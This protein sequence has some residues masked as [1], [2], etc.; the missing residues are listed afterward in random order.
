MRK[1]LLAVPFVFA[2]IQA[3][4]ACS[5]AQD[6]Q[7]KATEMMTVAQQLAQKNPQ[8]AQEWSQKTMKAA[9]DMQ[10]AG[11]KADDFEKACKFYDELIAEA[12]KGL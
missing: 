3:S 11:I 6:F 8:A 9:Q 5:T 12:K 2:S 4:A 7:A 1:Y 10:A